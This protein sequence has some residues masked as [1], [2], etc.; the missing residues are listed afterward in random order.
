MLAQSCNK[1][2]L[3]LIAMTKDR[4]T[5]L[6]EL[7]ATSSLSNKKIGKMQLYYAPLWYCRGFT[8]LTLTA[9]DSD[10]SDCISFSTELRQHEPSSQPRS[11]VAI[12]CQ[13]EHLG[14]KGKPMEVF[15]SENQQCHHPIP[16]TCVLLHCDSSAYQGE[17]KWH[18][19]PWPIA[20]NSCP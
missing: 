17:K 4:K 16:K 1:L 18:K 20:Q 8:P 13:A 10:D 7:T 12:S 11:E 15:H 2:A 3:T 6:L 14:A 9:Y 19:Q 5:W